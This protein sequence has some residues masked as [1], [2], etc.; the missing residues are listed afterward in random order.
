VDIIKFPIQP[1]HAI[2]K[3]CCSYA[4]EV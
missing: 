2:L 3:E 1:E 4:Y